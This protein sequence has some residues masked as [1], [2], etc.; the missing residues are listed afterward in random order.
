MATQPDTISVNVDVDAIRF[1][2]GIHGLSH[3]APPTC[4]PVW[5]IGVPRFLDLFAEL[6]LRATFFVVA[7]DLVPSPDGEVEPDGT[8]VAQRRQLVHAMMAQ[9]H[10]V[11]SHSFGHDYALCRRPLAAIGRDLQRARQV[12][13]DV[14]GRPVP[15]FR[16]PGY[17]LSRPLIDAIQASGAAYSSSRLPSPPY[18]MAKWLVMLKGV[19]QQ[20]RSKS[21]VGEVAA[22]FFSRQPYRHGGGLLELPISVMPL[23]RLPAIGTFFTLYGDRGTRWLLPRLSRQSWLNLEFHGIDLVD[24]S[25]VGVARELVRQQPD[26]RMPVAQKRALFT[27]WLS[28]LSPHRLNQTLEEVANHIEASPHDLPGFQWHYHS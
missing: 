28:H 16:A 13:R 7:S 12:L 1:Y 21:I 15:G 17:N 27:T 6:G 3:P 2:Y 9:G 26:L 20:R 19:L 22:P 10:E 14:T 23:L 18:F 5:T 8:V 24:A 11:A 4:D 25:D